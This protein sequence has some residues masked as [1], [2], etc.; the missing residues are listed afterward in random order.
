M[1]NLLPVKQVHLIVARFVQRLLSL[2]EATV[3]VE[4][5]VDQYQ[6]QLGVNG[7][8]LVVGLV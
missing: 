7:N 5:L 1:N 4:Q 6:S 8:Q 2:S 3:G